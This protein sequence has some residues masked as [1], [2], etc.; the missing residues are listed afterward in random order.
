MAKISLFPFVKMTAGG[1]DFVLFDNRNET[2]PKDYVA[3]AKKVCE[4]K[5][6]IGADG[7]LILEKSQEADFRMIY[8]NADGSRAAMCGNGARCIARFAN[9]LK[10][11]PTKMNFVTDAGILSA[12]VKGET[13]KL[14]MSE[15]ADL[16]LDFEVRLE[17]GKEFH[18][19]FINTGVPHAVL[20][21]TDLEKTEVQELGKAIRYHKEFAP[22][23]TNAN[24]IFYRDEHTLFIRTY[25]RGV[26][27]ETL[28]CGT[29]AV[30]AALICAAK[31]LVKSPVICQPRSGETLKVYF[32]QDAESGAFKDVFLEGPATLCYKGEIEL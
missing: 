4:R 14:K 18:L 9:L 12:E 7:L 11:A 3:L 15:P 28:A 10:I 8:Y 2:I 25:E 13:V 1:N 31:N 27:G 24:F 26:E 32:Q 16:K 19:S 23:G 6:S 20:M 22:E 29:G 5:F 30:A 21:V 17:E